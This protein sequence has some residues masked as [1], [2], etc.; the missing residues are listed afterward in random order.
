VWVAVAAGLE[1]VTGAAFPLPAVPYIS[2]NLQ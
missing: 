2:L 1:V